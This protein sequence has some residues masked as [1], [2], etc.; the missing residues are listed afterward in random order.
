MY[1]H[2]RATS[3]KCWKEISNISKQAGTSPEERAS[4]WWGTDR[5][6]RDLKYDRAVSETGQ[7]PMPQYVVGKIQITRGDA[8][9]R[10]WSQHQMW[11]WYLV[12]W[13][14]RWINSGG[15]GT[16]GFG[17]PSASRHGRAVRASRGNGRLHHRRRVDPDEHPGAVDDPNEFRL[18]IK[19]ISPQQPLSGH[20]APVAGDVLRQPLFGFVHGFAA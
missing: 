7:R 4:D 15:L 5:R 2:R 17:L 9:A 1:T 3:A 19:I 13:P 20:G 8:S 18:P 10:T 6:W 11:A 12:R 14:R 16:M